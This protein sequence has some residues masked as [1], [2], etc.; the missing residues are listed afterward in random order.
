MD[1]DITKNLRGETNLVEII[2][3]L[4]VETPDAVNGLERVWSLAS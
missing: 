4:P 3:R 1:K 2:M